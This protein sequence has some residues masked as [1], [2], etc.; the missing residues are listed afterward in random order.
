METPSY[1]APEG[2]RDEQ[3]PCK[4]RNSFVRIDSYAYLTG[5]VRL[6][7]HVSET[8][9]KSYVDVYEPPQC[10]YHPCYWDVVSGVEC[11]DQKRNA[12]YRLRWSRVCKDGSDGSEIGLHDEGHRDNN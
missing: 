12:S 3:L 4:V 10:T 9:N 2:T 5:C 8:E 6:I 1:P 7:N 11:K